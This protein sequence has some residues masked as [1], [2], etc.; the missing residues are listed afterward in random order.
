MRF[1]PKTVG[2]AAAILTVAIWTSFIMIARATAHRKLTP[3]DIDLLRFLGAALGA[4]IFLTNR[5]MGTC[6]P[7]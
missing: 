5:C 7:G 3:L 1:S 6:L 4:V 2:A